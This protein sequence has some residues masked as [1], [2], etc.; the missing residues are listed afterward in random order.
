[1]SSTPAKR[2]AKHRLRGVAFRVI[3]CA[4]ALG[5]FLVFWFWHR[6]ESDP[7]KRGRHL[8]QKAWESTYTERG[9]RVP[10]DGPREGYWGS[11]LGAKTPHPEL[12][13]HEPAVSI[14]GLV[15][16]DADGF[17]HYRSPAREKRRVL[18]FGGS[19]AFGAY[20]SDLATTYFHVLGTE[21]E[22]L[23]TPADITVISSGAWRSTQE[24][25]ALRL[26][27]E[28]LRPDL[29]V[30]LDGL[31]DIT[32]EPWRSHEDKVNGYLDNMRQAV[33]VG[34]RLKCEVLFALQPS[35]VERARRSAIEEV[36]LDNAVREANASAAEFSASYEA[37]RQ[38]LGALARRPGVEFLDCSRLFDGESATTF[39]DLWHFS[40]R[41]H[42]IL[43]QA[44]AR[45]ISPMFAGRRATK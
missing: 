25:A 3:P 15:E 41:G 22:A 29:V 19:V 6:A 4:V 1:M 43:G 44:L 45:Q 40:D 34:A 5:A 36:V 21:L 32:I 2:E 28:R 16:I 20:A 12:Q 30:F 18:V 39:T 9:L 13:W 26:H 8:N 17:Q 7:V 42:E 33:E 37:L 31:N 24:L 27:G 23:G 10:P 11:R 35:L 38:G 14:P